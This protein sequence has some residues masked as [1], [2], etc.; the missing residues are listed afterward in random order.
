M[1]IIF[2]SNSMAKAKTLS[3]LQ[4]SMI[5]LALVILPI[6]LTLLLI[7]PQEAA[8]QQGVKSLIPPQL[9]FSF[10]ASNP[11]KHLDAY[12]LQLGELQARIMRL[13]AQSE[14]LAKLAGGKKELPTTKKS[15]NPATNTLPSA[16]R[17]GPL[18]LNTPF[19]EADL[20]KDI[21]ELTAR[22]EFDTE[23]LSNLEA[24]LLQQSVLKGT[25]PNSSPVDA[26]FNSSSYGWRID[27]F[28]GNKAFHE[29]LD[30]SA[31][32]GA[33]IFSAAGG[34]VTS[35]EYQPDYGKIVKI[36]HG[37]GLETRY[38]HASKLLVKVGERVKKGQVVAEVGN[39]GR[40]TGAHLHYEIRL[41][42]NALDPRKYLNA[43]N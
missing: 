19:S 26:A 12:A 38:A 4:V 5:T 30:F 36:N 18:V 14:R 20:Q 37:S 27:P 16:N 3:V 33:P 23:Y 34:I 24:K 41:N 21:T 7:V 28:N 15:A 10:N 25:L 35:A 9:R 32:T 22:V 11:Q 17:G 40:S 8:V 31:E 42:G 13:D 39:T 2:I 6:L 1:N 43:S 29:G